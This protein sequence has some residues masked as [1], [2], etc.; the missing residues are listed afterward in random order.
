MFGLDKV[1]SCA[2]TV[3]QDIVGNHFPNIISCHI[4]LR[5]SPG[6]SKY[7]YLNATLTYFWNNTDKSHR[8]KLE[9]WRMFQGWRVFSGQRSPLK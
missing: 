8:T 2:S 1:H 5:E 4:F 6:D 9:N 7:D 3:P